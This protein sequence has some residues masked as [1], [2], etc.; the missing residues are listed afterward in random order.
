MAITPAEFAQKWKGS[1]AKERSASQEHFID[2][3]RMLGWP[4]P[5]DADPT[6]E[7]YAFEKGA[8][9]SAGGDGFA[10]V[11]KKGYFAWE[12]KGK[13]HDLV[14]AY[15]QLLQYHDALENPPLLVVCDLNRFE[16]HTKFTN[17]VSTVHEFDLDELETKPQRPLRL[18]R[19][20]FGNPD[21]LKPKETP[22]ELTAKAAAKFASLAQSIQSRGHEPHA[23]AHFL[24]KL[25]FSLFAED[26]GVLPNRLLRRLADNTAKD[27]KA[28]AAGLPALHPHE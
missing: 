7:Y 12:Y 13:K 27:P 6:G 17:A 24:N 21:E 11:W 23:T 3:C 22:E 10:D 15:Q 1:Q 9:K 26:A 8:E 2:L 18:L 4:T 28:F 14:A 20:V 5:N 19:A 16:I 25:L